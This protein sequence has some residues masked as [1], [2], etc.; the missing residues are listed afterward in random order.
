MSSMA[1]TLVFR[2]GEPVLA[3]GK[4]RRPQHSPSAQPG[5][6]GIPDLERTAG[7]GGGPSPS[8]APGHNAGAGKR[9]AAALA[10]FPLQQLK[11]EANSR[12]QSIGSGTALIQKI[13]AG[14]QGAA[15]PR[16]EGTALALP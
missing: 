15:D 12:L 5:A 16:R 14:W 11:S 3:L 10:R 2:N 4:P 13:G 8:F 9:S 7:A 1:P 6:P